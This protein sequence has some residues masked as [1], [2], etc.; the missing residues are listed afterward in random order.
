MWYAVKEQWYYII[1][2]T[3]SSVELSLMNIKRLLIFILMC[4]M[5]LMI[6]HGFAWAS[7]Y[8]GRV[9]A[10]VRYEGLV[11]ND[12]AEVR[13]VINT[14]KGSNLDLTTIDNDLKA[15]YNLQLFED[16]SVDVTESE[17]G[18]V[19]TFVFVELAVVRAIKFIGN[20]K[21]KNR[22]IKDSIL[23]KEDEV[24]RENELFI[25]VENIKTLYEEKGRPESEVSYEVKEMIEKDKKSGGTYRAVDVIFNIEESR[26]LIINSITF[27]GNE[28]IGEAPLRR[29]IET[30]ERGYW[31]NLGFFQEAEFEL[32]KDRIETYYADRGYV[33]AR[34]IKTDL[35]TKMNEQPKREEMDIT[36]YI[37][38]GKQYTFAG[39]EISGNKI[40]TNEEIYA[41]IT[42]KEGEVYNKTEWE[43]SVQGIR[44][45]LSSNGYIYFVLDIDEHKDSE[46]LTISDTIDITENSKAHVQN[47]FI[48]G[49]EKT[50]DF[51]IEREIVIKE[52]EIFNAGKIQRTTE[53][54][55]SLQYFSAI[56]IDVKPGTELGLVDLIFDVE[57]GRTGLFS[58]GLTYSTSGRG[59]AFYEEVSENN[60]LGRGL[61]LYEKVQVGFSQQIIEF[62]LDE[63]WLFNTPTSAGISFSWARTIYGRQSGD[64]VYTYDKKNNLPDGT[65]IPKGVTYTVNPDGSYTLNF[66]DAES[67]EYVNQTY[68]L[69]LRLG[70]R[71]AQYYGVGGELSLSVFQNFSGSGAIPYNEELRE[72]QEA[73]YPWNWK[74]Y[75]KL[76]VYRDSRDIPYFA[77]RGSYIGQD[78][79]LYGG[80][81]GGYSNFI[82]LNTE[83]NYNVQTFWKLV[84][85]ARVNFGF[86]V[87]YPGRQITADN[88]SDL[89]RVDT[90]NEGRGWSQ[91]SFQFP[92]LYS[93][94]GQSEFNFSLEY[95]YPIAERYVWGLLFFDASGLYFKAED[96]SLDP[97][98]L[99]YSFGLGA[100][101]VIPG[102][103]IRMYLA[104]RFKYDPS[105][106]KYMFANSQNF[107][108]DW[109][110][111]FAVAG[112]F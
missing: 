27:S 48:T 69:A 46:N 112:Y 79:Y 32:D 98:E 67:M 86:I 83:I 52:G 60:F 106:G 10:E 89:L 90:W 41:Q 28:V 53:K 107:F 2:L 1:Y 36:I 43:K 20:K 75:L 11:K 104:R 82:R 109:D 70:R 14:K 6:T 58:F 23:L 103:P 111:V 29:I 9:I 55:Y 105:A 74:N 92:S 19:V 47:I 42:L 102:I 33:D 38:E 12:V 22:T 76:Y 16:I 37:E 49:N 40:F 57:E 25:D 59:I 30:K 87:P 71:F 61:R 44:N 85:A 62:G 34:V 50:K 31:F 21:V 73:G 100:S 13:A 4:F 81:L 64:Q 95:R 5:M 93:L 7:N 65:N 15:L 8:E 24:F 97:K 54:L 3:I 35:A 51:V 96:F 45:L 39:V 91:P 101:L 80:L 110:F 94:R 88:I 26:K 66:T 17:S 78:L 72:E 18:I 63:P 68:R 56:N 77:K 99:W 108:R 84:L